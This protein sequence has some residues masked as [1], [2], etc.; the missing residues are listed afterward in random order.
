M[1][2]R[3]LLVIKSCRCIKSKC[4]KAHCGLCVNKVDRSDVK[5]S[6]AEPVS[7]GYK[8]LPLLTVK[9]CCG[10]ASAEVNMSKVDFTWIV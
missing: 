3:Q 8:Q 5:N 2:E 1:T 10:K 6:Y 9:H 4:M 7:V